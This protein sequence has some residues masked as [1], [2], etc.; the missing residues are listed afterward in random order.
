MK[1]KLT[2]SNRFT[3]ACVITCIVVCT[4][5]TSSK[6]INKDYIYFKNG[7]D[8]VAVLQKQAII[9][10]GD[11]LSVQVFSQTGKQEQAAVFNMQTS[12]NSQFNGQIQ[13]QGCQVNPAGNIV[14]PKIGSIKAAG[15]TKDQ[16]QAV[17]TQ[18]LTP[19]VL[20][21]LVLVRFLQFNISVLGE[22]RLPGTQKF[23]VDR[24]TIIDAISAAG[25][26]TDYGKREDIT[27]IREE[28]GKK[29]YH[30]IDL[31]NKD[32]FES[33]VYIL[34]PNDIVYVSPNKNKLKNLSADPEA[35]RKTGL[36][37]TITSVIVSVGT[38]II[39]ALR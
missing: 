10:P 28:D 15:L 11:E 34:Q 23:Q 35:Q 21:P 32:F 7:I 4:A 26:L 22:V 9:Q 20:D 27:V 39:T 29:I 25:D 2:Y 8:T 16:L 5:C 1:E 37:L 19:Y 14:I 33:P 6:K 31:R 30:R 3:I 38:L 36:F 13:I 24:V 18:K 17:L 12:A